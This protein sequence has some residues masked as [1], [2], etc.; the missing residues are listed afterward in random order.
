MAKQ[1]VCTAETYS[2]VNSAAM[3]CGNISVR[4]VSYCKA[5]KTTTCH[6]WS[7]QQPPVLL[8][9]RGILLQADTSLTVSVLQAVCAALSAQFLVRDDRHLVQQLEDDERHVRSSVQALAGSVSVSL[10]QLAI[11]LREA[12]TA[13]AVFAGSFSLAA[14]AHVLAQEEDAAQQ[15]LSQLMHMKLVFAHEQRQAVKY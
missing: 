12:L 9:L 2:S 14:A 5:G 1:H 10:K 15:L 4:D 3:S 11:A 13:L 7:S 6:M 8:V